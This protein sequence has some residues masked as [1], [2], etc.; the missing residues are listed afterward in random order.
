V[1]QDEEGMIVAKWVAALALV[2]V[3][4]CS[5]WPWQVVVPLCA[6]VAIALWAG[7]DTFSAVWSARRK[8][9]EGSKE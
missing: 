6:G 4:L 7:L 3:G 1:A 9:L 5:V 8:A 2:T